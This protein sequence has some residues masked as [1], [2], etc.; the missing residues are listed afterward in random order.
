MTAAVAKAF[1]RCFYAAHDLDRV[2]RDAAEGDGQT[3]AFREA[4]I[5]RRVGELERRVAQLQAA[6]SAGAG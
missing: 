5:R 6:L 4:A 3:G 2:E 1:L